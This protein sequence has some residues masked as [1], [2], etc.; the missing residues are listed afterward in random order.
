[1]RVRVQAGDHEYIVDE[2]VEAGGTNS[3]GYAWNGTSSFSCRL[4]ENG[5]EIVL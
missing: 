1:M 4:Q 3:G 5:N 2:P